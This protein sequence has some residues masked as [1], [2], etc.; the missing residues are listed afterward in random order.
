MVAEM[1]TPAQVHRLWD[2]IIVGAGPAGLSAALFLG[3]CRRS[4]LVLDDGQ[5]RNASSSHSHGF[6]TRD[7]APPSELL[8]IGR[9]QLAPYGVSVVEATVVAATRRDDGFEVR[10]G[11]V[12]LR[13]RKLLIA[14]GIVDEVPPI[15][16]IAELYGQSVFHCP[17]CDGWEVR[18]RAIAVHGTGPKSLELALA[19][20]TWSDDVL[21][22]TD[23][24]T[25]A[26]ERQRDELAAHG[27]AIRTEPVK[28]LHGEQGK[29]RAIEFSTG[30]S[31][32]RDALFF[33]AGT[34]QRSALGMGLGCPVDEENSVP[35][36][37]F[38]EAGPS[39]LYVI[40]D[41]SKDVHF[42]AVAVAE[43]VKAACAANKALRQEDSKA[44]VAA[45]QRNRAL[46]AASSR[47]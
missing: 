4:V 24:W 32:S 42:I 22:C 18:D 17:F 8:R 43:G 34:R 26:S 5:P 38:E 46:Q 45:Y 7:G 35:T 29:L 23:G 14:T 40:G 47:G 20:T 33:C 19:L 16:G 6:F 41:A 11:A 9:E 39:G 3:R 1:M 13:A 21:L 27:I 15:D 36:G 28:R 10:T 37:D 30:E 44:R 12:R 2:A 31:V 25:G